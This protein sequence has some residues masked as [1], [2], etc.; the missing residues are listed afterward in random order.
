VRG[1]L[2][3]VERLLALEPRPEGLPV[4]RVEPVPCYTVRFASAELWGPDAEDF[5]VTVDL[6]EP[7]LETA[8]EAGDHG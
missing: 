1:A 8:R 5:S 7:Y 2:G 3:T 6:V 4:R